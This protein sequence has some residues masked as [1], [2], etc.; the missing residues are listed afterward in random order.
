LGPGVERWNPFIRIPDLNKIEEFQRSIELISRPD[1]MSDLLNHREIKK[2]QERPEMKQAVRQILED[3]AI[4]D[5]LNSR[6]PL[7]RSTAWML[8]N[9]PAILNLADQPGFLDALGEIIVENQQE[10][11]PGPVITNSM[12]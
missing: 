4:R 5:A 6:H 3:P 1:R 10:T 7:D 2:L 11:R 12:L 9:H 8:M